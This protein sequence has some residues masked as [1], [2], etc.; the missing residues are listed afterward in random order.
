MSKATTTAKPG[1]MA[2]VF[3]DNSPDCGP[4]CTCSVCAQPIFEEQGPALRFYN[5]KT[6]K[7]VRFH[8]SCASRLRLLGTVAEEGE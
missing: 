8:L 6:K 3:F 4:D 2:V 5:Q 1:K 7:E